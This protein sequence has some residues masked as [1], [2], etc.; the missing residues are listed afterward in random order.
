MLD[1]TIERTVPS[2][3]VQSLRFTFQVAVVSTAINVQARFRR[4]VPVQIQAHSCVPALSYIGI[5]AVQGSF[6]CYV[7]RIIVKHLPFGRRNQPAYILNTVIVERMAQRHIDI[8]LRTK[9][10]IRQV[11]RMAFFTFQVRVTLG[12][13]HR[14]QIIKIRIQIP[15]ARTPD[16]HIITCTHILSLAE[17]HAKRDGWHQVAE[18]RVK[19]LTRSNDIFHPLHSLFIAHSRLEGEILIFQCISEISG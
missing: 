10:A 8:E 11:E 13:K 6:R 15:D 14:I 5:S 3:I 16:T 19:I 1:A 12:D 18:V 2:I 9:I 17:L 4:R 7:R